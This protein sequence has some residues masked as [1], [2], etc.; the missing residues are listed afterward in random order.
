MQAPTI[1]LL[2]PAQAAGSL[3]VSVST[4]TR[5]A[6]QGELRPM[7]VG[8]KFGYRQ[9]EIERYREKRRA[10]RMGLQPEVGHGNGL[11]IPINRFPTHAAKWIM[12]EA[13]YVLYEYPYSGSMGYV[14]RS[15]NPGSR[16]AG[17]GSKV[18]GCSAKGAWLQGVLDR[19]GAVACA[20]IEWVTAE[21]VA[22]AE[23]YWIHEMLRR[24]HRIFNTVI[25]RDVADYTPSTGF[26]ESTAEP[27]AM[28]HQQWR[29]SARK[30]ES[31]R[32]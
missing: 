5:L 16:L 7:R 23:R 17:H 29:L 20:I 4:L 22:R 24:G 9:D 31:G 3:A 14:G 19:G 12:G 32:P 10:V 11:P 25:P 30:Y 18:H 27:V 15:N 13:V 1:D 6:Q 2:T 28:L 21:D 26:D 8:R